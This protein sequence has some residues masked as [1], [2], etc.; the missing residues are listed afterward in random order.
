MKNKIQIYFNQKVVLKLSTINFILKG[1]WGEKKTKIIQIHILIRYLKSNI[2]NN[3]WNK[4]L[5]NEEENNKIKDPKGL[6][7]QCKNQKVNKGGTTLSSYSIKPFQ[8]CTVHFS[9]LCS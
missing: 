5:L 2:Q 1:S 6:T 8:C 7:H 9:G 3:T 4:I